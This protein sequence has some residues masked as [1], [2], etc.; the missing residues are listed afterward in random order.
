[1]ATEYLDKDNNIITLIEEIYNYKDLNVF[2]N[3]LLNF[4]IELNKFCIFKDITKTNLPETL[5]DKVKYATGVFETQDQNISYYKSLVNNLL[6]IKL[7]M[8]NEA[9]NKY[10][11]E[12][13]ILNLIK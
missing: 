1:M 2:I 9:S 5:L 3:D 7:A 10:I 6:N 13:M 4:S 8:K 12:A 11:L